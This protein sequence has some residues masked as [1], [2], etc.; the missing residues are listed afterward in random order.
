MAWYFS[1]P[2]SRVNI[3]TG[4]HMDLGTNG[5]S[6]SLWFKIL[7]TGLI[8][9]TQQHYFFSRS[10]VNIAQPNQPTMRINESTNILT[11]A[12][13]DSGTNV[14]TVA[15][16][17]GTGSEWMASGWVH[18]VVTVSSPEATGLDGGS[19]KY[20]SMYI[21][22]NT[23]GNHSSTSFTNLTGVNFQFG[24]RGDINLTNSVGTLT[25]CLAEFSKF[26]R[27]LSTTEIQ[28]L[29]RGHDPE[30]LS[31]GPPTV[32]FPMRN[33]FLEKRLGLTGV[34]VDVFVTGDHPIQDKVYI[35]SNTRQVT[36]PQ[37]DGRVG[38]LE[39]KGFLDYVDWSI[40]TVPSSGI[41]QTGA[42]FSQARL[43]DAY[44]LGPSGSLSGCTIVG[45]ASGGNGTNSGNLHLICT[46]L[47]PLPITLPTTR[48]SVYRL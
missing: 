6:L 18:T 31:N 43:G 14:V 26:D 33:N 15:Y 20:T 3:P 8:D 1:L 11:W 35:S 34:Q 40:G 45:Y 42:I 46:N 47:T 27:T 44:V 22:G 16:N 37:L 2:G 21:N 12:V 24:R 17:P 4:S 48:I 10:G 32:Y 7:G 36:L 39:S 41:A 9:G 19:T 28:Q 29:Y 23:V 30:L 5:W 13:W 25:G 38:Q